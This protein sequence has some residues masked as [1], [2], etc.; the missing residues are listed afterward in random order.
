MPRRV[1][2]PED[3]TPWGRA[4]PFKSPTTGKETTLYNIGAMAQA[5]GRTS[6]TVR[7]WEIAGTIPPTP[8]KQGVKRLYCT[9]QIE[10]VVRCVEKYKVTMGNQI[11]A[12]FSKAVYREFKKINEEFFGTTQKGETK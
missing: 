3:K 4:I 7:K 1:E 8:F 6:Q 10:A 12:A 11:P 2:R 5:I 9:E